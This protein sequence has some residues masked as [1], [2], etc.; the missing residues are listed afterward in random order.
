L[1]ALAARFSARE[2]VRTKTS[3]QADKILDAAA[4]L[5]GIHRFHEVRM[6]DIATEAGVGK[7]TL[8]R[9]FADKEELYLA[10]LERSSRRL[11]GRL[12]AERARAKD[13]R[14]QL[15]GFVSAILTF[16]DEQPHLLDLI[17]RAELIRHAERLS[18]W[19]KTRS[20]LF[21]LILALF[22]DGREAGAFDIRDPD[23]AMHLLLGGLRSVIRFGRRPRPPDLPQRVVE[24]FL[25]G[26]E[27]DTPYNATNGGFTSL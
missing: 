25:R 19:Q 4:R 11:V 14:E 21:Q 7:G 9:Y 24:V 13:A 17:Q 3:Q 22:E 5:F 18:P 20:E 16:F 26:A 15:L 12:Q 1:A 6:E 10:L 23:V 8:Y 2:S 27:R